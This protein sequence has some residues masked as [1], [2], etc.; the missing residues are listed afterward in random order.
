[1]PGPATAIHQMS[2]AKLV[3]I[4]DDEGLHAV[5]TGLSP[6][7]AVVDADRWLH[8]FADNPGVETPPV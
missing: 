8:F 1:M 3:D 5:A 7:P 6:L 4:M 2:S